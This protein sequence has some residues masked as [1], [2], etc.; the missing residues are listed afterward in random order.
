MF[1]PLCDWCINFLC[2]YFMRSLLLFRYLNNYLIQN[3]YSFTGISE[4]QKWFSNSLSF[5]EL[6]VDREDS[7]STALVL[8]YTT[9]H[10]P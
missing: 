3:L 8:I 1:L 5:L 9:E 6:A 4:L 7:E 10:D 2:F